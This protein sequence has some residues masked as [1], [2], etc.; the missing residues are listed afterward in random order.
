MLSYVDFGFAPSVGVKPE[1]NKSIPRRHRYVFRY[2]STII[3]PRI[4]PHT[5]SGITH[6]LRHSV[7]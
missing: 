6:T 3:Q 2:N 4:P 7:Q 5:P 1:W